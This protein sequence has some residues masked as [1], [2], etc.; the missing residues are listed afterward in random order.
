MGEIWMTRKDPHIFYNDIA[1]K[2]DLFFSDWK[3]MMEREMK[4][5]VPVL[6]EN[7]VKT[8]LDCACGTGLQSI[9]LL[10]HGF[11]V[12]SSDISEDMLEQAVTNAEEFGYKINPIQADFRELDK[13]LSKKFDA[14]ICMG[15]SLPHLLTDEEIKKALTNMYALLENKGLLIIEMRNYDELLSKQPKFIPIKLNGED[16]ER[17]ELV[18]IFYVLDYLKNVIRFNVIYIIHNIESKENVFEVH[19]V[20]YYPLKQ[21]RLVEILEE[22]GF[23]NVIIKDGPDFPQFF[24]YKM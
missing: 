12:L 10:K 20:D 24:S 14:V 21:D 1:E 9:G 17:G 18:T 7:K 22:V 2:Y 15:N 6:K 5:I 8:I 13:K 16:H 23:K 4:V 3:K 19:S 11:T